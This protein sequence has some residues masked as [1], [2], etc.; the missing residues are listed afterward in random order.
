MAVPYFLQADTGYSKHFSDI[1]QKYGDID[2]CL[3]PIA[4]YYSEDNPK[5]YRYVHT[6]PEDALKAA[7]ELNCKVM[8][9]LGVR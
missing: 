4:S 3:M 6:T 5:W 2:V 1:Q 8:I 9:P 7:H